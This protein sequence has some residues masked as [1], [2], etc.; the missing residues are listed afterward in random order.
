[1]SNP[2]IALHLCHLLH[3]EADFAFLQNRPAPLTSPHLQCSNETH[4]LPA[5]AQS[6]ALSA[7][8]SLIFCLL[9]LHVVLLLSDPSMSESAQQVMVHLRSR[10]VPC[11]N[12]V[13]LGSAYKC[14]YCF[15]EHCKAFLVHHDIIIITN[16]MLCLMTWQINSLQ[17][18]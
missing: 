15:E 5:C 1:V 11:L 2:A 9:V 7:I 14:L 4:L 3:T 10:E 13:A 8:V 12:T 17:H 6:L 18:F 16:L